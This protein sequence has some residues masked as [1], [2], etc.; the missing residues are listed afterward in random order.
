MRERCLEPATTEPMVTG[1]MITGCHAC[2]MTPLCSYKNCRSRVLY[3][4]LLNLLFL[5]MANP[6]RIQ[7]GIARCNI[8]KV[9]HVI[10][11]KT[12]RITPCTASPNGTGVSDHQTWRLISSDSQSWSVN[13]LRYKVLHPRCNTIQV[14]PSERRILA[15]P[16]SDN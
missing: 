2:D 10:Y 1:K 6:G 16:E 11:P 15:P 12:T 4:R 14:C 9:R 8:I 5:R 3:G 13:P 7:L